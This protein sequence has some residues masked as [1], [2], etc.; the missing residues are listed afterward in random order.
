[1]FTG[2]YFNRLQL[3]VI[4]C[5]FFGLISQIDENGDGFIDLA[6]L[7]NALDQCGF[8]MPG[9]KVRRMIEEYDDKR[10]PQD[11]GRLSFEEF[12]KLCA[13]LRANDPSSSFKQV[14]SK[15][16][17]L[18]TLGGISAASSAGTTHSVRLEEQLAFSDW[19]NTNLAHDKDLKHLLPIDAEG[20]TLYDKV[21]DGIL[22]W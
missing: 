8:K 2:L 16:E 1:M 10:R 22:F 15:K 5:I 11:R 12:E 3:R 14:V 6:E 19:I 7:R 9:Y 20:K 17:N 18:E 13:E 21:K 4:I